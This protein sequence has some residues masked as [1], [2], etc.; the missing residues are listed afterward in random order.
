M[1]GQQPLGILPSKGF[2]KGREIAGYRFTAVFAAYCLAIAGGESLRALD[3][4]KWLRYAAVGLLG[5]ALT[6]LALGIAE[7]VLRSKGRA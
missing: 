2:W 4:N 5:G 3:V 7:R 6:Y 1:S